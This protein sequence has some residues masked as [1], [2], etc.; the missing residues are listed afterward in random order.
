[1]RVEYTLTVGA[2]C[3]V[4]GKVDVY[5]CVVRA[6]RIIPVE[7]TLEAAKLLRGHKLFQEELTAALHRALQAEVETLGWHS[8]VMTRCVVGAA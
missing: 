8:G 4:D 3:P 7:E 2:V 1:M 6:T 5:E